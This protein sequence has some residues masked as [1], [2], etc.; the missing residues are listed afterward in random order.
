MSARES[1]SLF[2]TFGDTEWVGNLVGF[3]LVSERYGLGVFI[4]INTVVVF[5]L[6]FRDIAFGV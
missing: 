2:D 6:V 5:G 1:N 4:E 3:G